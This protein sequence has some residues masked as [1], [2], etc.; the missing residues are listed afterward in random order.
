M[1]INDEINGEILATI[2]F[3]IKFLIQNLFV[4]LQPFQKYFN[5]NYWTNIGNIIVIGKFK[6]LIIFQCNCNKKG[7]LAYCNSYLAVINIVKSCI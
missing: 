5:F 6:L 1:G 2:I 4:L 7:N 3:L